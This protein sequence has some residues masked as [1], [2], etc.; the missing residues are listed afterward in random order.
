MTENQLKRWKIKYHKLVFGKTSFDEK[1]LIENVRTI[2]EALLKAR[3]ASAKG[4]FIKKITLSSTMGPGVKV[5]L[6]TIKVI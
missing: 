5:D 6:T 4:Q 1:D 3:P 2:Y